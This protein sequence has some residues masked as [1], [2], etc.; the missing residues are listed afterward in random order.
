MKYETYGTVREAKQYA[1]FDLSFEHFLKRN[2]LAAAHFILYELK[3]R[4]TP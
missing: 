3:R 4:A 2:R 1:L